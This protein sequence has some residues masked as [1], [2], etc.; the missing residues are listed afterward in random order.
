MGGPT[1][2]RGYLNRP[3]LNASRFIKRP[4][5]VPS[6]MGDRLYRCGDWGFMRTDGSLEICGRCDSMTKIRGYSIELQA[7]EAALLETSDLVQNAVCVV[8]GEEGKEKTLVSYIVRKTPEVTVKAI[9]LALKRK[10]PF[11]MIPSHFV[12][13]AK[14]VFNI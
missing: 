10:V 6:N 2:A 9:R 12:F 8:V 5:S 4:K 3:D 1:L 7:V 14:L 13:L 11:Y